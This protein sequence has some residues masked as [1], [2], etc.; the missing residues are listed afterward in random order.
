MDIMW[1]SILFGS[2]FAV[3]LVCTLAIFISDL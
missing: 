1:F 3:C 2:L